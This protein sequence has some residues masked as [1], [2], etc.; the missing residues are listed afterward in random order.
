MIDR[1][2][3]PEHK[4]YPNYGGRGI[5]VCP[6]WR[7]SFECWLSEM[8]VPPEGLSIDRIDNDGPY[9]KANCRWATPTQQA[10]N[11]RRRLA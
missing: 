8:G 2:E 11:K 5:S 3:N 10:N 6:E 9:T 7:E 4:S 1:C